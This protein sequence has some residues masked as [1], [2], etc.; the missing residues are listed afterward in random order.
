MN[1]LPRVSGALLGVA[2]CVRCAAP[3]LSPDPLPTAALCPGC[4]AT[5]VGAAA[6]GVVGTYSP[7]F[8]GVA[9]ASAT[10]RSL[11]RVI[12]LVPPLAASIV[13][14]V[15]LLKAIRTDQPPT[16]AAI[17][18]GL[19]AGWLVVQAALF[20]ARG[21][22]IGRLAL[23]LRT[24]DDLTGSPVNLRMI[25][26]R[27]SA[28]H[29]IR[30]TVT[31][32]LR[33]GRDPLALA[34]PAI[35]E[36]ALADSVAIEEPDGASRP[37]PAELTLVHPADAVLVIFDTGRRQLIKDTLLVGRSPENGRTA[38]GRRDHRVLGLADLSR[39]LSKTHAL[40]EW[41]GTVL[42]VTD[43]GS[44]NG[45]VLISP[46]GERR[47]LVPGIRGPAAIGWTVQFGSRTFR[48]HA[49]DGRS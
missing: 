42:W 19:A 5:L 45:S 32:D 6:G 13:G 41:S 25:I 35:R 21:R 1:R 22:T 38:D 18:L 29:W 49:T 34:V 20:V 4:G 10:R 7:L 47:P 2:S 9:R 16:T 23:G 46:D 37:A 24:V 27:P 48:V 14:I 44:A 17:A 43:L 3:Q 31:A 39:T 30:R 40:L 15:Q 11:A 36:S 28:S 12:D 33:R 8:A 26:S